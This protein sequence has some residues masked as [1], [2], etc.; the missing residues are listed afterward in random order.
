MHCPIHRS[1][2]YCHRGNNSYLTRPQHHNPTEPVIFHTTQLIGGPASLSL[3]RAADTF[4]NHVRNNSPSTQPDRAC[5]NPPLLL[6]VA[7]TPTRSSPRITRPALP[8]SPPPLC[9][10]TTPRPHRPTPTLPSPLTPILSTL[11]P[12]PSTP[13][14][15]PVSCRPTHSTT[16]HP[17]LRASPRFP[18]T[19]HPPP[20][21][22][23]RYPVYQNTGFAYGRRRLLGAK[24]E[25]SSLSSSSQ[26][27]STSPSRPLDS[28][29]HGPPKAPSAESRSL[30]ERLAQRM[31]TRRE[32]GAHVVEGR[33]PRETETA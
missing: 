26:P 25:G 5:T 28:V 1:C 11:F 31:R 27:I 13:S 12:T 4:P 22:P 3:E 33:V 32:N 19:A 21:V 16:A 14:T 8:L 29:S 20:A 30:S 18:L 17:V 9:H 10:H 23:R 15:K 7:T 24:E 2:R 6:T